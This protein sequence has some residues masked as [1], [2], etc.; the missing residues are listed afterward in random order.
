M[1]LGGK[2][3]LVKKRLTS[4]NKLNKLR[5]MVIQELRVASY[6]LVLLIFCEL[7]IESCELVFHHINSFY[8]FVPTLDPSLSF[9]RVSFQIRTKDLLCHRSSGNDRTFGQDI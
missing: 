8:P 6:E 7:R 3:L 5:D 2:S 9:L 4:T 1:R